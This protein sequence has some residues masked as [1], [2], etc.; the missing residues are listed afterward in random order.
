M[1]AEVVAG[2]RAR[3]I[4][5]CHGDVINEQ[6]YETFL[7]AFKKVRQEQ[8]CAKHARQGVLVTDAQFSPFD[9]PAVPH[10]RRQVTLQDGVVA[11]ADGCGH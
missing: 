8:R 9:S 1:D 5:P 3:R 10:P 11:A 4:V 7:A 2:W 6:G